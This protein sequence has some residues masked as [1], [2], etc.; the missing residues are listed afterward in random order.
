VRGGSGRTAPQRQTVRS[1]GTA[2]RWQP[3]APSSRP[4]QWRPGPPPAGSS[5]AAVTALSW[6]AIRWSQGTSLP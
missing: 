3:R 4:R 2:P 1:D 5:A 6:G